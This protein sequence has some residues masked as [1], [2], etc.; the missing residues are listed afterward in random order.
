M[1]Y[2][3]IMN[4]KLVLTIIAILVLIGAGFAYLMMQ[5]ETDETSQASNTEQMD[6][7]SAETNNDKP[8]DEMQPASPA[9]SGTYVEYSESAVAN[10][11]GTKILFFYAPWCPQC[12][13]LEDSIN[14]SDIPSDVTIFKVDYDTNQELRQKYGVTI[15]TTLVE[16]DDQ[17][18]LVQKYVA[19]DEPD[20]KAVKENLL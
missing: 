6:G 11:E 12:R 13:A 5:G 16:I 7:T 1:R 14:D 3:S 15:Q 2:N 4:K 19:Y 8:R 18:N 10:A 20:F 17:G 9:G